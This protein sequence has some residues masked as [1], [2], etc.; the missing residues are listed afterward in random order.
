[1][2]AAG[3]DGSIV[4]WRP[5]LR[6]KFELVYQNEAN[7]YHCMD[8]APDGS[9]FA[10]AGK[11]PQIEFIDEDT[12]KLVTIFKASGTNMGGHTNRIF[13][14]K[15]HPTMPHLVFS[16]GWDSTVLGWDMRTSKCIGGV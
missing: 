4:Q 10:V 2:K 3:S 13:S 8:Y 1:L 9:K 16:G 5:K 14:V 11:L 6:N 15:F 7:S 12:L